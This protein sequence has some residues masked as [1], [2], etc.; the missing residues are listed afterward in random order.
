MESK[1][2]IIDIIFFVTIVISFFS[3][4]SCG[5]TAVEK[6]YMGCDDPHIF[7][8]KQFPL[9]NYTDLPVAEKKEDLSVN[10]PY[11]GLEKHLVCVDVFTRKC[12]SP[13]QR[14]S[15]YQLY[16][17]PPLLM[18]EL[19]QDGPYQDEYL[20]HAPCLKKVHKEYE[21]CGKEHQ[22]HITEMMANNNSTIQFQP[23]HDMNENLKHLCRSFRGYLI[24]VNDIVK[25]TCGE[26]TVAFTKQFLSEMA[27]SLLKICENSSVDM[28]TEDEN[29][30]TSLHL[31]LFLISVGLVLTNS[32]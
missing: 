30:S 31:S 22:K 21:E 18:Q 25:A 27:S 26:T 29:S 13:K 24:C 5:P 16:N 1:R 17:K 23:S 11:S 4:V 15:F 32:F 10:C 7:N 19:C 9:Y 20:K 3:I 14:S 6:N 28:K 8:C 2:T 12:M